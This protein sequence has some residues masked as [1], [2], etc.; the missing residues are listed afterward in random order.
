MFSVSEDLLIF[1]VLDIPLFPEFE[2]PLFPV[3]EFPVFLVL[4]APLVEYALEKAPL[5]L[6]PLAEVNAVHS[7]GTV[8]GILTS[9]VFCDTVT[10][11]FSTLL[12]P[13]SIPVGTGYVSVTTVRYDVGVD[14]VVQG[15][16]TVV[17]IVE[18]PALIELALAEI[19]TLV[20]TVWY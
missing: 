16:V 2:A 20:I 4:V 9:P 5:L 3:P 6:L 12:E 10:V 1:S 14:K 11:V 19:D 15:T 13:H 17:V 18:T 8:T 7:A